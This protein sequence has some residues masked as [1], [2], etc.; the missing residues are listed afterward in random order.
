MSARRRSAA[1]PPARRRR[2]PRARPTQSRRDFWLGISLTSGSILVSVAVILFSAGRWVGS[3]NAA[4]ASVGAQVVEGFRS[5]ASEH[6]EH[7]REIGSQ[8]ASLRS[9][10]DRLEIHEERGAASDAVREL[11]LQ[12]GGNP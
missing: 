8:G 3:V 2:R 4:L 1:R 12:Q 5:N 9:L 10:S 7:E 6:R 11:F